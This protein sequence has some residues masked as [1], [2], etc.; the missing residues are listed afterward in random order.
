MTLQLHQ[1]YTRITKGSRL[2]RFVSV[3]I[4]IAPFFAWLLDYKI[5]FM[6]LF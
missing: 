3:D 5:I 6:F 4:V 2:T 1:N